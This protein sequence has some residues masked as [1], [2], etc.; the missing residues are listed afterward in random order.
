[1]SSIYERAARDIFQQ[2]GG[3]NYS[4]SISFCEISGD[5]CHD[6]LNSFHP[7]QLLT[8]KDGG[9]YAFPIVEP[10][11]LNDEQ[12]LSFIQFGCNV[13]TTAAT[14]QTFNYHYYHSIS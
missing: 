2:L 10:E 1:M 4:V 12:L 14:G 13:R 9:V 11:V 3:G 7:V 8:G 5:N 6:L